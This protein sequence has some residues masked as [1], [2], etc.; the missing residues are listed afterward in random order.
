M[1]VKLSQFGMASEMCSAIDGVTDR[2]YG[3]LYDEKTD[4]NEFFPVIFRPPDLLI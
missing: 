1:Q 3:V 4:E 2:D